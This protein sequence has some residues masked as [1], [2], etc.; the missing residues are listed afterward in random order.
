MITKQRQFIYSTIE[1]P[2]LLRPAVGNDIH[3]WLKPDSSMAQLVNGEWVPI[4]VE[5]V[6]EVIG[7]ATTEPTSTPE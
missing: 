4:T 6:P 2:R 5:I 3:I 7:E 1:T